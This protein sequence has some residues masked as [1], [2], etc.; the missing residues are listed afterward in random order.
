MPSHPCRGPSGRFAVPGA[1]LTLL[2]W[3]SKAGFAHIR[4][5]HACLK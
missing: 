3:L 1:Y 4:V 5:D 2:S